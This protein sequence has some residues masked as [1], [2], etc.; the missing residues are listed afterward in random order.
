M[1]ENFVNGLSFY[2]Q[3]SS[4]LAFFAAYLGGVLISFTPC[5]Y[6]VIPIT[7][8]YIGAHGSTSKMRGFALS[9][10]YVLGMSL[11]Y[12]VLGAIAALSGRL[13]GQI[14]TNPW[15]YFIVANIC[16]L[17]G[18]SMLDVFMLPIRTPGFLTRVQPRKKGIT[19]SFFIGALSGLV[20][21][22][23][24]VP[25][26]AALLGY[27]ATSQNLF[28]GMALLFIFAFGLGTLLILLG[29]F[30]GL[31]TSMPKSGVWMV[32]ITHLS[33]WILLAVGEYFL[34][35]AGSFWI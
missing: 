13:F 3:G 23:C 25:V 7:I 10:I 6:P 34:I 5:V 12:M 11:T 27:V 15:T 31:L 22:P 14:Q 18:L 24:T 1:I 17:M 26:F 2:L 33:G 8:A 4:Y 29:T 9:V 19:G 28:F 30:T 32:R 16:I 35:K 20:M 21:G